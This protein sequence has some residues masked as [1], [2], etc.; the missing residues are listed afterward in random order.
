[1]GGGRT[2]IKFVNTMITFQMIKLK[3]NHRMKKYLALNA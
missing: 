1:M 3:M 2:E